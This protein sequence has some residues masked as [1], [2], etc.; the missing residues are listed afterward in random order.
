MF[1][2][3]FIALMLISTIMFGQGTFGINVSG[4]SP[5]TTE[6]V[7]K[8]I[9]KLMGLGRSGT[10]F[11]EVQFD[12]DGFP[13]FLNAGQSITMGFGSG[14][15]QIWPTG[16][17]HIFFDGEGT[18][19]KRTDNEVLKED[20][21]NGHQIWTIR[22]A[23]SD[24][25]GFEITA[26]NASNYLK[27]LRIIMPG[28]ENDYMTDPIHPSFKE[29]W[30]MMTTFRFM[31]WAGSNGSPVVNWSQATPPGYISQC[32]YSGDWG[33]R[34][35]SDVAGGSPELA[36]TL[37]NKMG[38]D[39]WISIPHQASD[40]YINQFAQLV[41]SKLDPS[42]KVY[43]EYSNEVWNWAFP[44][45]NYSKNKGIELGLTTGG[46]LEYYVYRSGQMYKI[47]EDAWGTDKS[48]IINV[49]AWQTSTGNPDY[50]LDK[51]IN[52]WFKDAKFNPA[53]THPEFFAN[54]PYIWDQS[55]ATP[56]SVDELFSG[57]WTED[58]VVDKN[59][60]TTQKAFAAN[61]GMEYGCY[62]AGQHYSSYGS[63]EDLEKSV[64]I[65]A[66]QDAR[67]GILYK[68]YLN[69]WKN[70]V[71]GLMMLYSSCGYY[72]KYGSWGLLERYDQDNNSSPKFRAA[73]EV[74]TGIG[75]S[76]DSQPPTA[77]ADLSASTIEQSSVTLTWTASTDSVGVV[78]YEVLA[79]NASK[80]NAFT[81]SYTVNGLICNTTYAFT[82]KARDASGNVS[83]ASLP[84][85]VST[86]ACNQNQYEAE[87]AS[88]SGG[89][90]VWSDHAGF[91][92]TGFAGFPN[93]GSTVA[94]TVNAT[95]AGAKTI[96]LKY[97]GNGASSISLF[98][99]GAKVKQ[100][101]TPTSGWDTWKTVSE[102]LNLNLGSNTIAFKWDV[103]D[104]GGTNIDNII[105]VDD[106]P[107]DT[108]APSAPTALTAS[109][110][111][112]TTFTLSWTASSD[113]VGVTSYEVFEGS[114]SLGSTATTSFNVTGL[115]AATTYA[116]TVKAKDAGNTSE[117]SAPLSV[118]T[119]KA[120]TTG[121]SQGKSGIELYPNPAS[122]FLILNAGSENLSTAFIQI[123]SF[124]GKQ[125]KSEIVAFEGDNSYTLNVSE[126]KNGL[127]L[128]KIESA[129][130]TTNS[131]IIIQK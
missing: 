71:G 58:L 52:T 65:P 90:G 28:F 32:G 1:S 113:N 55:S 130:K 7:F 21:G 98:L 123:F 13:K 42:L 124:D 62:E 87:N 38:K 121:I 67:M 108:L 53:G 59:I 26:T 70:E 25:F 77:P 95:A 68:D 6:F 5:N 24:W 128:I 88:L 50:W 94:F 8:D 103:D 14:T 129:G 45:A 31:D 22:H 99:N 23:T 112:Q 51:A 39:M 131:K 76:S 85:N 100:V 122:D 104:N 105:I 120:I 61:N 44:Q 107:A 93:Q 40:E 82:V 118:T 115:S 16:D 64:Y 60:M 49:F 34:F 111:T 17:Y 27:N 2:A 72:S 92:G 30:S 114:T 37:C 41:K 127:Y 119:E 117:A 69:Y 48:R 116:V 63:N 33:T 4:F 89:A 81:N 66:N 18:I 83:A 126:L 96:V 11:T 9:S 36:I 15:N 75:D 78:S 29:H 10:G 46:A 74:I 79:G 57:A 102:V 12:A 91:T 47:W 3:I 73:K 20:L 125:V 101:A 84:L 35:A 109:A 43:I 54:A 19:V 86:A 56:S 106:S 110:I 97:A 80:G